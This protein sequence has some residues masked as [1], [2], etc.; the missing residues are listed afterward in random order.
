MLALT[1]SPALAQ[2]D[3]TRPPSTNDEEKLLES[4]ANCQGIG[5]AEF[6]AGKGGN[7]G[8]KVNPSE[9]FNNFNGPATSEFVK[10]SGGTALAEFQPSSGH[11]DCG[12]PA[13]GQGSASTENP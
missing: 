7:P 4:E 1:V 10:G 9:E 3:P 11:L 2:A 8:S 5:S 12:G 6:A 13:G